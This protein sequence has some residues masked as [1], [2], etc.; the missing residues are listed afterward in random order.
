VSAHPAVDI[1]SGAETQERDCSECGK[2][3]VWYHVFV[4]GDL[5]LG[6]RGWWQWTCSGPLTAEERAAGK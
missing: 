2:S 1:P 6:S 5:E 3:T 4:D